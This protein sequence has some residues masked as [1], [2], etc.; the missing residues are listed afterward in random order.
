MPRHYTLPWRLEV[1][2]REPLLASP[3]YKLL[4]E[5]PSLPTLISRLLSVAARKDVRAFK[6]V[7]NQ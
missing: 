2:Y 7:R 1:A 5:Y 6:I 4:G 3:R